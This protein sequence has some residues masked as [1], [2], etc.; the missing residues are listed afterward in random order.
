MSNSKSYASTHSTGHLYNDAFTCH[1]AFGKLHD[2][3]MREQNIQVTLVLLTET[4]LTQEF[5]DYT[6]K[7]IQNHDFEPQKVTK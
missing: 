7:M 1:A 4:L 5:P 6:L 3:P 2:A